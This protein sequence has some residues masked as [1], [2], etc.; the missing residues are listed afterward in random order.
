MSGESIMSGENDMSGEDDMSGESI[1]SGEDDMSGER[2]MSGENDTNR[3]DIMN[4]AT[5][6]EHEKIGNAMKLKKGQ[7]WS[8]VVRRVE[9]PNKG[10]VE[11][12]GEGE[13]GYAIVKNVMPGQRV[14]FQINKK[15]SGV[16]QGRLL[17]VEEASTLETREPFCKN[18]PQCGGCTYQTMGRQSQLE[19]KQE[20]IRRTLTPVIRLM[21]VDKEYDKEQ[22]AKEIDRLFE[23]IRYP[24]EEF[25]YRNKMEFSFGDSCKG[26]PLCLGLHK[27]GSTYDILTTDD[28]VLVHPDMNR[29]L[30]YTLVFCKGK[31]LPY[32]HKMR[33]EGYL[34]H[35]LVR[36]GHHTGELLVCIVTSSQ[37]EADWQEYADGLTAL[38]MTGKIVGILHMIND[39]VADV[40]RSDKTTILRGEECFTDRLFQLS[41]QIS[42]FSFFQP[43][44]A[45]A[46]LIYDT[47]REF[48]GD[49]SHKR[50]FDLFCGTGTIAQVLAPSAGEVIGVELI[51]EAVE[52]ARYNAHRNGLHNCHFF[53]GDVFDVLDRLEEMPDVIVV[54]PPRDGIQPKTLK[55][56]LDYGVDTIVYVSCKMTSLA[57]DLVAMQA[58]GYEVKRVVGVD[59]FANCVHV[60]TIALIQRVKS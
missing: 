55:K 51:E 20:Q 40:V 2:I 21:N 59:Q 16:A 6:Q 31:K 42:P 12:D 3:V 44:T 48:I 41:F 8:G 13:E 60:E 1:M 50:V 25:H 23:P 28:C 10:V 24:K 5:G 19:M 49:V 17:E 9:F 22:A 30:S 11:I 57:R 35:L 32:Y 27:K 4:G 7:I 45:G 15:K 38:E 53:A 56:I 39:G 52:S 47:V 14:R 34:R 29:I 54:D 46:E 43:N 33:H 36:R 58:A 26:G 37:Y 18:F